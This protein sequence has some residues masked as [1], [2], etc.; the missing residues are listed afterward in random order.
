[1]DLETLTEFFGWMTVVN[2]GLL[3]F[4]TVM[5]FLLRGVAIKM[6]SKMFDLEVKDL[7]RAYFQYLAHFKILVLVF[8]LAPYLAL[9]IVKFLGAAPHAENFVALGCDQAGRRRPR[10]HSA[11]PS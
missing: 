3:I 7:N 6:H 9:K 2:M 1:M 5:L 11:C 8:N 4:S 10:Q